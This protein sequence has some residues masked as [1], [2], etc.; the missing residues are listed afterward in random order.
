MSRREREKERKR[1]R[2]KERKRE[3]EKERKR[4]REKERRKLV[5]ESYSFL[6][7]NFLFEKLKIYKFISKGPFK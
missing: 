1:E 3:R 7:N 6:L 2:Q 4:E 5:M